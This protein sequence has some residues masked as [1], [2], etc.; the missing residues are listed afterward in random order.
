MNLISI[1]AALA[2]A[3]TVCGAVI[4][5]GALGSTMGSVSKVEHTVAS[6]PVITMGK[7]H[8][9]VSEDTSAEDADTA[10]A[11]GAAMGF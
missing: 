1:A 11:D 10:A 9:T 6:L 8:G 2:L 3:S 5:E 4:P 7:L